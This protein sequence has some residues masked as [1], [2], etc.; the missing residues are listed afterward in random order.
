MGHGIPP[1]CWPSE[2]PRCG[3]EASSQRRWDQGA[4]GR[5]MPV[6]SVHK[7]RV[8]LSFCVPTLS[9]SDGSKYSLLP[10]RDGLRV[11]TLCLEGLD[12]GMGEQ[13]SFEGLFLPLLAG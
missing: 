12:L 8:T 11:V 4:W 5:G 2:V 9:I 6:L 13:V 7:A 10:P 1:W 3:P